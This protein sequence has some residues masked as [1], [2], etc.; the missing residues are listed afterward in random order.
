MC[1]SISAT[2][3]RPPSGEGFSL[4]SL[5]SVWRCL[6]HARS[7]H[8]VDTGDGMQLGASDSPGSTTAAPAAGNGMVGVTAEL[9]SE[10]NTSASGR[11]EEPAEEERRDGQRVDLIQ[12][13]CFVSRM[14]ALGCVMQHRGAREWRFPTGGA[15][16]EHRKPQRAGGCQGPWGKPTAASRVCRQTPGAVGR[17]RGVWLRR[18]G[19]RGALW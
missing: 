1:F 16:Q 6:R 8:L 12:V 11:G 14:G 5:P 18:D 3:M 19:R 7:G 15:D 9:Q 2:R 10:Q 13:L 4:P 17:Q